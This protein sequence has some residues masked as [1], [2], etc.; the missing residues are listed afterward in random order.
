MTEPRSALTPPAATEDS[1][2]RFALV[3]AAFYGQAWAM[4]VNALEG[5]RA[6]LEMRADGHRLE[7]D[8]ASVWAAS[9]PYG[10][11]RGARAQATDVAI[12]PLYGPMLARADTFSRASGM[13]DTRA[14]A[15]AVNAAAQDPA[16]AEIILDIDSPGGQVTSVD[17]AARAVREAQAV[18]PVTAV[19]QGMM[20]SAAY[21]VAAQ[22]G[23][24]VASPNANV[25]S[26]SVVYTHQDRS[27]ALGRQGIKV[28]TLTTGD[29]KA[30]GS[31]TAP[32]DK[33]SETELRRI[34]SDY[35]QAFV[36]AV[37]QGRGKSPDYVQQ[38]WADGRVE[39]GRIAQ[40]IGMI[41]SIG[42]LESVLA[43]I[44]QGTAASAHAAAE[45]S[46][47]DR[48]TRHAAA[49]D[50]LPAAEP[51]GAAEARADPAS[52]L[53][54]T[55]VAGILRD[56]PRAEEEG[57]GEDS[58][59]LILSDKL[60]SQMAAVIEGAAAQVDAA[61]AEA[62]LLA[63]RNLGLEAALEEERETAR[64]ASASAREVARRAKAE[65]MVASAALPP[66]SVESDATFLERARSAAVEAESDAAAGEAVA[67]LIAERQ[68]IVSARPSDNH[69][70]LK[71]A[72]PEA[73][74]ESN[75]EVARVRAGIPDLNN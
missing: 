31:S 21:W 56:S 55:A 9:Q 50:D 60:A 22:A 18:K 35:H 45:G 65:S 15:A 34:M 1:E 72:D 61:R 62:N 49:T 69:P 63:E 12:I 67:A 14:F 10:A 25:G 2:G 39:T 27:A 6:L 17:A 46:S 40:R 54:I 74:R 7:D 70:G 41:D 59:V 58:R 57:Q 26:I 73:V 29:K 51:E 13:T 11:P 43:D 75:R 16:V 33:A 47:M 28:T 37:A 53:T 44:T 23:R 20:A 64:T 32:L 19:T 3:L 42:T 30:V 8:E 68:E 52:S 38:N 5:L 66:V 71:P 24:I 48:T 4:E 36:D